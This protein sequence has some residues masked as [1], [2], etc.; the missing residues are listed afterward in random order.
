MAA[1]LR[2][3]DLDLRRP[4]PA[5]ARP[6]A[7][8]ARPHER[9]PQGRRHD[10]RPVRGPCR[11][12]AARLRGHAQ[13]V[14]AR[15]AVEVT[16]WRDL[17]MP[18]RV[19]RLR[20]D[21]V[22]RI[23]L[24][25]VEADAKTRDVVGGRLISRFDMMFPLGDPPDYE[26]DPRIVDRRQAEREGRSPAEVAYDV[27][28]ARR[29]QGDALPAVAELRQRHARRR[30]RAAR[31]PVIGR[32]AV[33]RRRP[34]RHDLRRQLPD[35]AAAVVG[36]R[37]PERPPAGRAAR[38]QADP[39][40]GRDG[41]PA[42]PRPARTRLPRRRQRHRLRR[43]AP[44]HAGVR[45]RPAGRRPPPPPA[46][47]RLPPHVRR[48]HRDPRRRRVDRRHPG[49][50][51]PRRPARA[52]APEPSTVLRFAV[53]DRATIRR[54]RTGQVGR[55]SG[56]SRPGRSATPARRA[57][58]G[59]GSAATRAG[60]S[61]IIE[62]RSRAVDSGTRRSSREC[63]TSVG[64]S[65]FG[66]R[67]VTSI[68]ANVSRNRTALAGD[69]VSRCS[70]LNSC[71]CSRVPSGRN[72]DVNTWRNDGSSRPHPTRATSRSSAASRRSSSVSPAAAGPARRRPHRIEP[73][74]PLR[75]AGGERDGHRRALR[76]A[77]QRERVEAGGVDD[78]LEVVDPVVE[79]EA[80]DVPVRH[81][82]PP[83]VVAHQRAV[84]GARP[85]SQCRHT[86]V[87]RSWSRWVSQFAALTSTGPVA[88]GGEGDAGAVGGG[89]EA[90]RLVQRG[91]RGL[92]ARRDRDGG[93]RR[94]RRRRP[95]RCSTTGA[96]NW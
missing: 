71:H 77:E 56:R 82:A 31:P 40:D 49:P 41:R 10:A 84:V 2:P 78:Q 13:P 79:V 96:T 46:G 87:S 25:Q 15:P 39:G 5:A 65:T 16:S 47:R 14:H 76:H 51:G 23:L 9:R 44:A 1:A 50:P 32:R 34:R 30:R 62:A 59:C 94:R 69:V 4:E 21:D 95:R 18:E 91:A 24:E 60:Q 68:S 72:C 53:A 33:R 26:P 57:G 11:R 55:G 90:D 86:N 7:L 73:G 93:C 3:A 45:L 58:C 8:P 35:L 22:R 85:S 80:L 64:Q 81:A 88:H 61:G 63:I 66:A 74:H 20:R 6:V 29:R 52:D 83:L 42:R 89:A 19:A 12:P 67:S 48:R 27:M 17:P 37:P 36:P 92:A 54:T 38:A 75:V 43:P 70:S 28:L